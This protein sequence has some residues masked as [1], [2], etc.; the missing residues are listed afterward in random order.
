MNLKREIERT[1]AL[2]A[3]YRLET[4]SP[5]FEILLDRMIED[6]IIKQTV[7]ELDIGVSDAEADNQIATIAKQNGINR[8]QLEES[9][10]REGVPFEVYRKNI[11]SQ[12]ERRNLFDRELRKGGGIS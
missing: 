6:R 10:R 1:P 7:K 12:L 2:A 3:A 4:K 8:A 9:L 5:S 11:K